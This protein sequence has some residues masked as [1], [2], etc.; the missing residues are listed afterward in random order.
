MAAEAELRARQPR[1]VSAISFRGARDKR[2]PP[3]AAA[4]ILDLAF[5]NFVRRQ[6]VGSNMCPA[7]YLRARSADRN[8]PLRAAEVPELCVLE[9]TCAPAV[10]RRLRQTPPPGM[11]CVFYKHVDGFGTRPGVL[12]PSR[13]LNFRRQSEPGGSPTRCSRPG[14]ASTYLSSAA[15]GGAAAARRRPQSAQ[16]RRCEKFVRSELGLFEQRRG[17]LKPEQSDDAED[18]GELMRLQAAQEQ[19]VRENDLLYHQGVHAPPAARVVEVRAAAGSARKEAA[20]DPC[21][22]ASE[23]AR[24]MYL[25]REVKKRTALRRAVN[26]VTLDEIKYIFGKPP[27]NDIFSVRLR[28]FRETLTK[29]LNGLLTLPELME[30]WRLFEHPRSTEYDRYM[31]GHLWILACHFLWRAHSGDHTALLKTFYLMLYLRMYLE[32][33]SDRTYVYLAELQVAVAAYRSKRRH[34]EAVLSQIT[35][36]LVRGINWKNGKVLYD[37]FT[38]V[39]THNPALQEIFI[40]LPDDKY[41][42]QPRG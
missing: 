27:Y 9:D 23:C 22:D 18:I 30:V 32:G 8:R 35:E 1:P 29:R 5:H 40:G 21:P 19:L 4:R 34:S 13:Y 10:Q 37:V 36:G 33:G 38:G 24:V 3:S 25:V 16:S 41:A 12:N 20:D 11:R 42:F 26:A 2:R 28:E 15:G 39:V 7:N 14:S 17:L 31:N 6:R